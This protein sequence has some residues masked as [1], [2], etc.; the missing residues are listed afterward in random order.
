MMPSQGPMRRVIS[1][2]GEVANTPRRPPRRTTRYP[3]RVISAGAPV[4]S[5]RVHGDVEPGERQM[6][7]DLGGVLF[8]SS[9]VRG[10]EIAEHEE[11]DASDTRLGGASAHGFVEMGVNEDRRRH[12]RW[13]RQLEGPLS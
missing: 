11:V 9:A 8:R 10:V 13:L 7:A 5:T 1:S 12:R 2:N 4:D 3:S 6:G